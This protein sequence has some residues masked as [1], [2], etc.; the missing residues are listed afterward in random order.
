MI[1]AD[2]CVGVELESVA[3]SGRVPIED[4]GQMPSLPEFSI[5]LYHRETPTNDISAILIDYLLRAFK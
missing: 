5:G 4:Q 2:L 1:S 3:M